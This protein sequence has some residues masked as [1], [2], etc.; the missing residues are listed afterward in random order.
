MMK[1]VRIIKKCIRESKQEY[2]T[3]FSGENIIEPVTIM[4]DKNRER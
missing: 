1:K 4:N 2:L 3:N